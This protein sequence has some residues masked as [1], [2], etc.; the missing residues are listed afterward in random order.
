LRILKRWKSAL[1]IG[2]VAY[3][4][5]V[6]E[7]KP[8]PKDILDPQWHKE[9]PVRLLMRRLTLLL[10][11][12]YK[13]YGELG[14]KALQF[15]FYQVGLDR[16]GVMRE[17]LDIDVNDARS[18]GRI[19]DYED[20]L[21]GVRGIWTEETCGRAVKE[22]RYC[23]AAAELARCPEVCTSL[24]M[25]MEAGTFSVLNP[26]LEM[27]ELTKLLSRGDDCCLAVIELPASVVGRRRSGKPSL[28]ATP[29]QF[30][31]LIEAP[32][33]R[34]RLAATGIVSILK[35]VFKLATSGPDQP[36]VWYDFF[37]YTG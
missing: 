33:L 14:V 7:L 24:M 27:P 5:A 26:E 36:M 12:L 31:P 4:F 3:A 21:V 8:S 34:L 19:L 16:A 25:A 2:A 37:R 20:G 17:A 29:G 23:P 35:A 18:L 9:A 11:S 28:Q 15:V 10:P 1:A 30:P 32:G 13:R 6:R 22:E